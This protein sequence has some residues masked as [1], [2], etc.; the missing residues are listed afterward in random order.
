MFGLMKMVN[1]RFLAKAKQWANEFSRFLAL[2]TLFHLRFDSLRNT[3]R[4]IGI[5]EY[6]QSKTQTPLAAIPLA[7]DVDAD[8]GHRALAR[9]RSELG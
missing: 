6:G 1:K 5:R 9:L 2:I 3:E 7:N 4:R 8:A